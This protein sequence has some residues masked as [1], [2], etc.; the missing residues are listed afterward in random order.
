LNV[1]AAAILVTGIVV[2]AACAHGCKP[3]PVNQGPMNQDLPTTT[4]RIGSEQFTLEVADEDKEREVGLMNRR[5][6]PA[7][8]GMI[9]VFPREERLAFYMK[10]TYIPL[11]IIYVDADGEVVSIHPMQPLDVT[12]I[13]TRAP[14]KYAIELNQGAAARVGVKPGDRL[15]IPPDAANSASAR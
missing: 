5:S 11:D 10:N 1:S 14:A 12:S 8:H 3:R 13:P 4:M 9:F 6:M 7:N 2:A 15:T